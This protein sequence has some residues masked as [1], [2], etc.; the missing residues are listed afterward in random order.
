[1]KELTDGVRTLGDPVYI[2]CDFLEGTCN[3]TKRKIIFIPLPVAINPIPFSSIIVIPIRVYV[4][5]SLDIS[6]TNRMVFRCTELDY[7][8]SIN[9]AVDKNT[10]ATDGVV[11]INTKRFNETTTE[12]HIFYVDERKVA[13]QFAVTRSTTTK[14]GQSPLSLH[15]IMIFEFDSTDDYMFL[16]KLWYIAKNFIQYLCYRENIYIPHV[17][18]ISAYNG[19]YRESA[20]F[21]VV[22][23]IGEEELGALSKGRF[24]KLTY[25]EDKEGEILNDI[26]NNTLFHRHLPD[27]FYKSNNYDVARFI[28]IV[29]AFEWEFKC[30]YP[31]G[32]KKS[33]KTI[34]IED[35]VTSVIDKLI[36]N[37]SGMV[38]SKYKYLKKR[39]KDDPL[40]HK[41]EQV[42][43][44]YSDIIDRF[45]KNLYETDDELN[46]NEIGER[47]G[48]QRNRFAHGN[49]N[50]DFIEKSLVDIIFL[51]RI[52]YAMQ[53]NR[54]DISNKSIQKSI[55]ELFHCRL[56]L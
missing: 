46:Y 45:G 36:D 3:E 18:L 12:K 38:K 15:S 13:V 19:S 39:I 31:D 48:D 49:L 54:Y 11:T 2:D 56:G 52:V 24:I 9:T 16:F 51:E 8:H 50:E 26:A 33:D 29:S 53:L 32:I 20:I 10:F 21:Y 1:M 35:E 42:G 17:E 40:K 37:S 25:L 28:M 7:I 14:T 34:K 41:I 43:K 23:E 22:N 6:M 44:D 55:N 4:I 5:N 30:C 47:I 27:S